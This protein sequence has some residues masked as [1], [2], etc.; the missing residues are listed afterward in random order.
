MENLKK[1]IVVFLMCWGGLCFA[2]DAFYKIYS[3]STFDEGQ[4]IAQVADSGYIITGSTAGFSDASD[5]FLTRLNKFGEFQWSKKFGGANSDRGRRVFY[6]EGVGIW[7][8]GYT[9]SLNAQSFD[10]YIF[11]TDENGDLEW[12]TVIG[13]PD[14]ERLHD[15]VRLPNGDFILVGE[16]QGSLSINEDIFVVRLDDAGNEV[17]TNRIQTDGSD[18]AHSISVL[19]DTTLVIAGESYNGTNQVAF[20]SSMHIDGSTNWLNYY[21]PTLQGTFYDV[22]CD[23]N[24]I[25]AVGGLIATGET[26]PDLWM[27]KTDDQGLL[28]SD[29][30]DMRDGTAYFSKVKMLGDGRLYVSM[31]SDAA[32]FNPFTDG[33]DHFF[34]KYHQNLFW[35]NVSYSFSGVNDDLIHQMIPTNDG[36]VAVIGTVSDDR[37]IN[38]LGTDI[39]VIKVGENDELEANATSDELVSLVEFNKQVIEVFPNPFVN[40][41]NIVTLNNSDIHYSILTS[42]GRELTSGVVTNASIDVSKLA[43]GAY[44]L[45]LRIENEVKTIKLVK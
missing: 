27:T 32:I 21:E 3:G 39:T 26:L 44:F 8:M 15:A 10:F 9:N 33:V 23:D 24:I 42:E 19:N 13:T 29:L 28:I 43:S 20:L 4:G 35:N 7:C 11:K 34:M 37:V 2:Q 38:T 31:I 12:E 5:A 17:W 41:L 30:V 36:G 45:I 18:I 1:L 14:W 6:E 40:T 25:Y 16:T 22:D